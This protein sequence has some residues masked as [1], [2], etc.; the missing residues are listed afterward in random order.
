MQIRLFCEETKIKV[1][2]FLFRKLDSRL[3]FRNNLIYSI[4][5]LNTVS[6]LNYSQVI[7]I[8]RK[9]IFI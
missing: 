2:L 4:P 5:V 8:A 9:L 6:T 3:V 1:I 7:Y